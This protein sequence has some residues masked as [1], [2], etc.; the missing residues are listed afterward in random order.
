MTDADPVVDSKWVVA[1]GFGVLL[2]GLG[3][4][5]GFVAGWVQGWRPW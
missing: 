2:G 3:A 1:L 4:C 5:V